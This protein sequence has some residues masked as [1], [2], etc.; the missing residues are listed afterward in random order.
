MGHRGPP[1]PRDQSRDRRARRVRGADRGQEEQR[2]SAP[3]RRLPGV[4]RRRRDAEEGIE[5]AIR[6]LA[7][8]VGEILDTTDHAAGQEPLLLPRQVTENAKS[9]SLCD[10]EPSEGS[11]LVCARPPL[12]S[13]STPEPRTPAFACASRSAASARSGV[14]RAAEEESQVARSLR[15]GHERS[16]RRAIEI[17]T[18]SMS[19]TAR[20]ASRPRTSLE[21]PGSGSG[22]SG[23]PPPAPPAAAP[24]FPAAAR[25][26]GSSSSS[27]MPVPNRRVREQSPPIERAAISINHGPA[28]FTRSSAWTGPSRSPSASAPCEAT[29]TICSCVSSGSRDGVT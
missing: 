7:P 16:A 22:S 10:P 29:R 9:R 12:V 26:E 5:K 6:D 21:H 14:R 13:R 28:S 2:L 8:R 3:R 18:S 17:V 4:R 15:Q 1:R 25:G 11:A 27:D 23:R 20:A 19:G 24:A